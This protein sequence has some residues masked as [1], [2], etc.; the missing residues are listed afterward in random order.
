MKELQDC[1]A[2]RF[3]HCELL[4]TSSFLRDHRIR[5]SHRLCLDVSSEPELREISRDVYAAVPAA[6]RLLKGVGGCSAVA[7]GLVKSLT[8]IEFVAHLRSKEHLTWYTGSPFPRLTP[9]YLFVSLKH[10]RC[11][12]TLSARAKN[13]SRREALLTLHWSSPARAVSDHVL[14]PR[15]LEALTPAFCIKGL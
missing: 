8:E 12:L 7:V 6:S 14:D 3:K 10:L 15:K 9:H 11:Y 1:W 4:Q 2:Q 13:R 5:G